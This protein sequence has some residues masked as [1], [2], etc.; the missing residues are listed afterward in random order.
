MLAFLYFSFLVQLSFGFNC[1][2]PNGCRV[3]YFNQ[4]ASTS[5]YEKVFEKINS[6]QCDI[7]NGFTFKLEG[8][9][10]LLKEN[11][12]CYIDSLNSK[13]LIIL[14]WKKKK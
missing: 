9:S 1:K 2:I 5:N 8:N 12:W 10:P 7:E 6:I 13:P 3:G 4:L 11:E 14:K